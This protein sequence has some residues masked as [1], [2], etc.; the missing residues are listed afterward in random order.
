MSE[1]DELS[2]RLADLG[3][4]TRALGASSGFS[5]RV[6]LAVEEASPLPWLELLRS[7]RRL[8]PVA[9]AAALLSALWS[10]ES[11]HSTDLAILVSDP[12]IQELDF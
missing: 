9:L 5:E 12:V 11:A 10:L 3:A 7:G 4:R 2:K 8:L 1:L 6:M